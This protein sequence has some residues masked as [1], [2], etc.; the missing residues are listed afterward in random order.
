M[1]KNNSLPVLGILGAGKLGMTLAKL[2]RQ[3]GYQVVV[4]SSG[5]AEHIA[6]TVETL[7]PGAVAATAADAVSKADI[8]ILALPLSKYRQIPREVMSGKLVIDAMNYW[9]EVD[10]PRSDILPDNQS[11][12]EA[13]QQF[14]HNSRV[15]KAISH[16]GYHHLHDYAK[17]ESKNGRRAIAIAGDSSEDVATVAELIDRLGFDPLPIGPLSAGRQLEPG[18]PAFGANLTKDELST[19]LAESTS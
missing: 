5:S 12:S 16:V 15:V 11:S 14:L 4:A 6:L 9:W 8:V 3:V 19:L 13:V 17:P 2:A 18:H 1:I 10:G 7:A